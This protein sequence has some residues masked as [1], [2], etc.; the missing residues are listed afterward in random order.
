[1]SLTQTVT[2]PRTAQRTGPS[3]FHRPL[4]SSCIDM[5]ISRA[6][7]MNRVYTHGRYTETNMHTEGGTIK[8]TAVTLNIRSF[9]LPQEVSVLHIWIRLW[10]G[11][12]TEWWPRWSRLNPGSHSTAGYRSPW[13]TAL[14]HPAGHTHGRTTHGNKHT[15]IVYFKMNHS[16]HN[17][18]PP[19]SL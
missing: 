1:M 14:L 2:M 10:R 19:S 17:S 13:C 11:P 15:E 12:C 3:M 18:G 5:A 4:R 9:V 7:S 16:M 6:P 8:Q